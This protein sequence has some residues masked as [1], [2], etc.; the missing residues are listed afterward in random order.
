[1]PPWLDQ[2]EFWWWWA[3][4]AGLLAIEILAPGFF[5]LWFAAAAAVLGLVL[6]IVPD[7]AW[8]WQLILFAVLGVAALAIGRPIFRRPPQASDHP[9]LN[10]RGEQYVG[11]QLTLTEPIRDGVGWAKVDDS[12]WRVAG[13]DM[14]AG[15]HVR[16]VGCLGATLQ[17]EPG[18]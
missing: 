10:R 2:I 13:P 11:R 4:A 6:L 12:R 16:V 17:V 7:L 14:P 3:F 1:M 9:N 8:G 15:S 5:F 18:A